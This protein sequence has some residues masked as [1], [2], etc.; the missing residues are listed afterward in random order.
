MSLTSSAEK[1]EKNTILRGN[2][3]VF[4]PRLYKALRSLQ[5][6][7][8]QVKIASFNGNLCTTV[9][10]CNNPKNESNEYEALDF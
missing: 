2:S 5:G 6:I 3:M 10:S 4:S 1:G 8:P 7:N 9:M